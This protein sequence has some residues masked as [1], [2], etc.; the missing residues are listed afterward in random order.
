M[1]KTIFLIISFTI[2]SCNT[3]IDNV[4]ITQVESNYPLII[5]ISH[6][7]N[8]IDYI[9]IPFR[10]KISQN[11]SMKINL[12]KSH[13]YHENTNRRKQWNSD[14]DLFVVYNKELLRPT[15]ENSLNEI[16]KETREFVP[17]VYY[18]H[19]TKEI[20]VLIY[21]QI[22]SIHIADKDTIHWGSIQGIKQLSPQAIKDFLQN[23][24]ISFSFDFY[25]ISG[26]WESN[27]ISLPIEIK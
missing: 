7:Q 16:K 27:T 19:L 26:K 6:S 13:Y 12:Y 3:S 5:G 20:Q 11:T 18:G 21:E 25:D 2:F 14:V 10:F 22:K 8:S 4:T 15:G 1:R 23:D 17:Y 24:S 9:G